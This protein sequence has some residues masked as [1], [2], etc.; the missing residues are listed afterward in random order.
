[1]V[2]TSLI[3]AFHFAL[4]G[5][6]RNIWLSVVTVIIL[7]LTLFSVSMVGGVNVV[8]RE[9]VSSIENKIDVSV[10]FN[11]DVDQ[12]EIQN[13]QY[14]FESLRSVDNVTF[15]SKEEAERRF[16]ERHVN[17]PEIIQSLDELEE[18]PLGATL[19][20]K[21]KNI[22]DYP[23]I[24]E[25]L[26][27]PDYAE[28]IENSNFDDNQVITDRLS[29][30]ASRVQRIGMLV[31]GVFVLISI[32]IIF[33]TIRI[34]IYTHREEI[35]IMKLVGASNW[36]IRFPFVLESIL[37]AFIAV[38]FAM[39]LLYPFVHVVSPY[40]AT[41]FEGYDFNLLQYFTS[42]LLSIMLLQLAI[43]M[44]LSVISSAVAV[45]KYLKV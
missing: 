5:F 11:P 18:N 1:M 27:D 17:D 20:I 6:W 19:V 26:E 28:L 31:T 34:T 2:V 45:G 29:D 10:Y 15:V 4:Q 41:L 24:L 33:N 42:N 9:V 32:L 7:V 44:G 36:F 35:G 23:L 25:M 37:Y 3:R 8:A 13:I 21:A 39:A 40:I 22:E 43:A 12:Q 16:R 30:I 38:L 14:R